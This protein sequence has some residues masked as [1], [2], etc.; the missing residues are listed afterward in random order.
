MG[1]DWFEEEKKAY[2][3]TI[4]GYDRGKYAHYALNE[5]YGKLNYLNDLNENS[6]D[7]LGYGAAEGGELEPLVRLCKRICIVD[8]TEKLRRDSI[9]GKRIE[10]FCPKQDGLLPFEDDSFDLITCYGVLMYII[11]AEVVLSELVRVL[12]NGGGAASSR[13]MY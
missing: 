11:N 5:Y 13:T 7:V 12:K 2:E 4:E 10:Y 6:L 1:E 9:D 8:P 3:E